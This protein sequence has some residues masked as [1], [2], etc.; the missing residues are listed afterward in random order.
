MS[1]DFHEGGW[2]VRGIHRF[3]PSICWDEGLRQRSHHREL[4]IP[5]DLSRNILTLTFGLQSAGFPSGAMHVHW[6]LLRQN[7]HAQK[8]VA[9]DRKELLEPAEPEIAVNWA[10][11][12]KSLIKAHFQAVIHNGRQLL[13]ALVYSLAAPQRQP[14][15]ACVCV[16]GLSAQNMLSSAGSG[17]FVFFFY[18]WNVL[19]TLL[20][21][22]VLYF[23]IINNHSYISLR[24]VCVKCTG[25]FSLPADAFP[26][27]CLWP[28][29]IVCCH[30]SVDIQR[31]CLTFN[32][33]NRFL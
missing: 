28:D 17:L 12:E 24:L 31:S 5:S 27:C 14:A 13:S 26:P 23:I 33:N 20:F 18:I 10:V 19:Q 30:W 11:P 8:K 1:H 9:H 16:V 32:F 25:T 15:L 4:I 6:H 21:L 22:Q 29:G 3:F 7:N 2:G